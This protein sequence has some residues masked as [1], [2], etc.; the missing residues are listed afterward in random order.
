ML[1]KTIK[2]VDFNGNEVQEDFYFHMSKAEFVELE[3]SEEGGWA[4]MLERI[5][6]EEDRKKMIAI[7]KQLILQAYGEKSPDGKRFIKSKELSEA[8]SQT[9]AYSAMFMSFFEDENAAVQFVQGIVPSDMAEQ[10]TI[11]EVALP[12]EEIK[13]APES[14]DS[15]ELADYEAWKASRGV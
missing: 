9:E 15:Q 8:F 13:K 11:E 6:K 7:F 14:L 12:S 3:V 1:K 5:A 4:E 10:M 2:W